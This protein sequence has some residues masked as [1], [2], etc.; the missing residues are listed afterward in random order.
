MVNV[1]TFR[2]VLGE[3]SKTDEELQLILDRT[4][5][6][7][8]NHHF[9]KS[10]DE[11]TEDEIEN[12]TNRYEYEIY[13]IAKTTIDNAQRGGLKQFSELGVTRVWESGGDTAIETAL[14][15]I[16]TKTYVW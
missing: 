8:V 4:I 6:K 1:E 16:P 12:F 10:D 9:W 15:Q 13:D 14:S 2:A 7:A 11:P 3:T 5:R